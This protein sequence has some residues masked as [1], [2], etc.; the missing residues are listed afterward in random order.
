MSDE[1]D[2]WLY[3]GWL[4]SAAAT[5]VWFALASNL[6]GHAAGIWTISGLLL[7]ARLWAD[8]REKETAAGRMHGRSLRSAQPE[9]NGL[10]LGTLSSD[11]RQQIRLR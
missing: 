9:T 5:A 6:W 3:Y 8:R 7:G 2:R 10:P 4:A 1:A 11:E